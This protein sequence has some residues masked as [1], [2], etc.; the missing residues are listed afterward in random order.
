MIM[1]RNIQKLENITEVSN[2]NI[3][4]N[5]LRAYRKNT[6]NLKKMNTSMNKLRKLHTRRLGHG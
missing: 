1:L 2:S 5:N 6:K 3:N 4:R